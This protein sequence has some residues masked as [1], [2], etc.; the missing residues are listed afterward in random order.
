MTGVRA[1]SLPPG[2]IIAGKYRVEEQIG[3]G[4]E[5]E[6]YRVVEERTGV[7]RAVKIFFPERNLRDRAVKHYARTLEELGDC[8]SVIQY[9]HTET[10]RQHG[11]PV[12]CLISE[13]VEGELLSRLIAR[14]P[15]KRML[16]FEAL[17]LLYAIVSGLVEI[18]AHG[19]YHGDLHAG[20]VLVRRTGIFY[21]INFVDFFYRGSASVRQQRG[22]VI[23]VIK[24]LYDAV[25]GRSHYASQPPLIKGIC[26]GLR[27]DLIRRTFPTATHLL[28]HLETFDWDEPS[29]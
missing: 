6:V 5:G 14:R 3:G 20:N 12:T 13:Y 29:R 28:Q 11:V 9:H 10:I 4:W 23:E 19:A 7:R 22:D 27:R 16:P 21:E 15:K 24:L 1:F 2:R 26:K 17:H 18:H 8:S 25:G